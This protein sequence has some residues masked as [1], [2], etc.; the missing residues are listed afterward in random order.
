MVFLWYYM[1]FL[2][3]FY[4]IFMVLYG[5]I[6]YYMV[7]LWY[8]WYYMVFMVL[9]YYCP[10]KN[11]QGCVPFKPITIC[12]MSKVCLINSNHSDNLYNNNNLIPHCLFQKIFY[13]IYCPFYYL[14]SAEHSLQKTFFC[15]L[16]AIRMILIY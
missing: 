11:P 5:T 14:F 12:P 15:H 16:L 1:V 3:Y 6:W 4:G 10:R 8:L 13:L 2:W 9:S 7:F